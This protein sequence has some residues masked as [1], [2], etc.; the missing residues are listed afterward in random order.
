MFKAF[1]SLPTSQISQSNCFPA[2]GATAGPAGLAVGP[3]HQLAVSCGL[4]V[5]DNGKFIAGFKTFPSGGGTTVAA[6]A[7]EIWY[8]PGDNH[9]FFADTTPMVL[10]VIDAGGSPS[11]DLTAPTGTGSHSVAADPI[12]NQVY[13]PLRGTADVPSSSCPATGCTNVCGSAKDVHGNLGSTA[14]GCIGVYTAKRDKD[15]CRVQGAPG[16]PLGG[17]CHSKQADE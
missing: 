6:G 12:K 7:D 13:V 3:D 14:K 15:D 11:P 1:A 8:N 9:Y 4:I 10:G 5:D 17:R 16:Q 2:P